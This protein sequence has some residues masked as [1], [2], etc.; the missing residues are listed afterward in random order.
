MARKKFGDKTFWVLI[1]AGLEQKVTFSIR[2]FG[3]FLKYLKHSENVCKTL[4]NI[5]RIFYRRLT[6]SRNYWTKT[7]EFFSSRNEKAEGSIL[8]DTMENRLKKK[9]Y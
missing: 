1:E 3:T 5:S 6:K 7:K 4:R 8:C 2:L 9:H